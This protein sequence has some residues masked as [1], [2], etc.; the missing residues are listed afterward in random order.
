MLCPDRSLAQQASEDAAPTA[1]TDRPFSQEYSVH[2][3]FTLAVKQK[4]PGVHV[5]PSYQSELLWFGIIFIGRGLYQGGIFKFTVHIPE[6]YPDGDCPRLLFDGPVFHP[7]VD[8][9]SGELDV[10]R[11]FAKWTPNQNHIW[12][13]LVYARSIFY[14]ISTKSPLNPNATMIYEKFLQL[15]KRKAA[16]SVKD[17]AACLFDPPKIEDNY[18]ITFSPWS[19]FF[20][21]DA[22]AKK[23]IQRKKRE[24]QHDKSVQVAGLSWVEPGSEQPL[25][26]EDK[27][28]QP[29]SWWS[30]CTT[31]FP[32]GLWP[33]YSMDCLESNLGEQGLSVLCV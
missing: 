26:K 9:N 19:P 27:Q 12:Q 4:L 5:Q 3:E 29:K 30:R 18:A 25:S 32:A 28:Y 15:F 11:A 8:P 33:A 2:A 17:C 16:E 1:P 20:P 14:E 23:L 31:H 21:Y 24:E 22:R 7:L 6:N 13:V 10:K